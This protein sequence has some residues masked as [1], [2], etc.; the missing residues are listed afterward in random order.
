MKQFPLLSL[1]LVVVLYGLAKAEV[2]LMSPDEL[3]SESS[4]I[5]IGKVRAVYSTTEKSKDW[6]DTSSIAEISVMSIEKGAGI[7]VGEVIYAHYWNKKWIGEGDPEPHSGGHGGVS[8]GD[9]VT[10]YLA[11]KDGGYHALLP[12]GF[13]VMKPNKTKE[14]SPTASLQGTW[15]FAYYK[16]EGETQEPG[17]RQF[18]IEGDKLLFRVRGETKIETTIDVND[19]TLDQNFK[20]GLRGW[21]TACRRCR[22]GTTAIEGRHREVA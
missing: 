5:V 3:R 6:E 12:N 18:V 15:N 13:A 22:D 11:R 17:T 4:H 7:N 10:A 19:G 14:A 20:D 21:D 8:K 1:L 9:F 16:E 2:P